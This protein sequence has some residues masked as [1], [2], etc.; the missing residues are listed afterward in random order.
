MDGEA[1]EDG[2]M[3]FQHGEE[4]GIEMTSMPLSAKVDPFFPSSDW[5]PLVSA[6]AS[7]NV[8]SRSH[9]TSLV[10]ENIGMSG[11]AHYQ[12][13]PGSSYADM[14]TGFL[15]PYG[16]LPDCNQIGHCI[17]SDEKGQSQPG[18]V[19]EGHQVSEDG[20]LLGASPCRKRR[21]PEPEMALSSQRNKKAVEVFRKNDQNKDQSKNRIESERNMVEDSGGKTPTKET[22]EEENSQSGETPKGNY[23]HV[24]TRRGQATKSHSL[25]ERVRREK[26][27]ERM[28][29]LQELVPGCS[30]ITGK[31]VMLDEIINYV[32]S[33]QQQVEFLSMKLS[34]VNPEVKI[35][36]DR[37]RAKDILHSRDENGY[38]LGLRTGMNLL[39][40]YNTIQGIIPN[41]PT[42]NSQLNPLSQTVID[43]EL[44]SIYQMVLVSNTSNTDSFPPDGVN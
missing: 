28:R 4:T 16:N 23:I 24:R 2:E 34:A 17:G 36:I 41:I 3:G 38:V 15:L 11:F 10:M 20:V 9:Y 5:D 40:P 8:F 39:H 29:L 42:T 19:H 6:M 18:K 7:T 44:Q 33:L 31:A 30:K 27:S 14:S 26:I 37:T 25:A 22:K 12:T 13:G 32:Q 43:T 1:G 35:D 21:Q